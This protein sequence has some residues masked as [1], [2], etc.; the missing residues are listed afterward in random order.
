M[1][2]ISVEQFEKEIRGA[3]GAQCLDVR[4]PSEYAQLRLESFDSCPLSGLSEK[5]AAALE[6][7]RTTY[8]L[9]R[10]G[11]RACQAADRLEKMGFTDLRV[12]E[13]GVGAF[14]AAG[15]PLIRGASRVWG[16]ERQV[17][18]AAGSLVLLGIASARLVHPAGI[19][20]SLFVAAGL[21]FSAVTDTCGMG[22]LLAR[23]PWNRACR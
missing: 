8:L 5:S 18:F 21:I 16:L 22:M 20:L 10:S 23:M 2:K 1:K 3:A 17:R 12:I 14:E 6:K 9:C 15:K 11:A 4:E 13:G 7:S 19:F